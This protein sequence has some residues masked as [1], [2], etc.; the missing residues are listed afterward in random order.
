MPRTSIG[1]RFKLTYQAASY[2]RVIAGKEVI[3]HCHHYNSRLQNT[4][5]GAARIDGKRIISNAAEAVFRS[6]IV[7][8]FRPD[9]DEAAKWAVAEGLY[10]HLGYGTIDCSAA[11]RGTVS[12]KASHFV[13]GWNAG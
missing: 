2:R 4:I 1:D 12:A 7:D 9:D 11:L 6:Q 10:A 8:S 5:E 3:L 13:E